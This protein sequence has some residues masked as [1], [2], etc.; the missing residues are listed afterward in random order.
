MNLDAYGRRWSPKRRTM[1]VWIAVLA[2]EAYLLVAYFAL[3][4]ATPSGGLRYLLYPF[5]WINAGLW[6]LRAVSPDPRARTHRVIGLAVA[7]AYLFVLLYLPGTIGFGAAGRP[8]DLRVAMYA[9]G[10]GPLVAFSSPWLRLYLVPF[11]VIGY[12]SLAYLVYA[13][14]LVL[15]RSVLSG[16]LG[17]VT[18]IG[19]TAPALAALLGLIGGPTASLTTTAYAWSYDIGTA[20]FLFTIGLLTWSYRRGR[21]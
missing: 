5:V 17:L 10:W 3:T 16:V 8:I 19:C 11:Q 14:V 7:G 9:P 20:I 18:C 13:N 21:S 4:P 6:V 1:G 2:I 12:A 15:T